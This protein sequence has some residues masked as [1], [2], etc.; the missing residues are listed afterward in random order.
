V[1]K[2]EMLDYLEKQIDGNRKDALD[3]FTGKFL[4]AAF[5]FIDFVAALMM[6]DRTD[7]LVSV[8]LF[9]FG[10]AGLGYIFG[11]ERGKKEGSL[12]NTIH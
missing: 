8:F 5:L 6:P 9:V 12:S 7:N 4:I 3:K 2:D 1:E 10:S 11:F